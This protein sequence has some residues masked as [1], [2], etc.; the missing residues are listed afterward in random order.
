ML[1]GVRGPPHGDRRPS[2][3][4]PQAHRR[5]DQFTF[6]GLLAA[7]AAM[8]RVD[9]RAAAVILATAAVEGTAYLATDYPPADLPLLSF[10]NHNRVAAAHGALV[11]GLGLTVPGSRERGRL[12]RC[13]LGT[14]PITLAALSDTRGPQGGLRA[15]AE[16]AGPLDKAASSSLYSREARRRVASGPG[17]PPSCLR[18][19][20]GRRR[21]PRRALWEGSRPRGRPHGTAPGRSDL[22]RD[23]RSVP[24]TC[25]TDSERPRC[26]V[27][28][29]RGNS[30]SSAATV[31]SALRVSADP[32]FTGAGLVSCPP[33]GPARSAKQRSE[34]RSARS[35][36]RCH[37]VRGRTDRRRGW[38]GGSWAARSSQS[39]DPSADRPLGRRF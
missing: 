23:R 10:G 7:A 36:R 32:A 26:H 13:T 14:M 6:P 18:R 20:R 28:K 19:P 11:I 12:A 9:R 16:P 8:A 17:E 39:C 2:L 34:T 27:T 4:S 30:G 25:R 35:R 15:V 37:L 21:R 33:R 22:F 29:E 5:I 24:A 31:H 38:H 1:P 3:L